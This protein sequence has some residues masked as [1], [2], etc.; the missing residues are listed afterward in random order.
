MVRAVDRTP[1]TVHGPS[2][3]DAKNSLVKGARNKGR[4]S[5]GVSEG[6]DEVTQL[7]LRLKH[8]TTINGRS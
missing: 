6:E 7:L 2:G 3:S 1:S 5:N 4:V 8:P